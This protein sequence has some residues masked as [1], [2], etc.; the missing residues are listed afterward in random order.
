MELEAIFQW[1]ISSCSRLLTYYI[2][3]ALATIIGKT[4]DWDVLVAGIV[5]AAI[6]GIGIVVYRNPIP[7]A[8]LQ[9][10]VIENL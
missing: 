4:G 5:F 6:E 8:K 2:A 1:K 9:S 10:L 7:I 3:N